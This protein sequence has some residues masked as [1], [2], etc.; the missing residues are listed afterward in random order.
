MELTAICAPIVVDNIT[1]DIN[2]NCGLPILSLT[3]EPADF[4]S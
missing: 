4:S 2:K 1:V 3:A